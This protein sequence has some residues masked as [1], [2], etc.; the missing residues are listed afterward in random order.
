[1]ATNQSG[2]KVALSVLIGHRGCVGD[3]WQLM[4]S[5]ILEAEYDLRFFHFGDDVGFDL[6]HRDELLSLA[7]EQ[8][9]DLIMLYSYLGLP[10]ERNL[11]AS[12]KAQ[13][14]KPIIVSN[15]GALDPAEAHEAGVDVFLP[16][17]F[18][19]DDLR[20]ALAD[21]GVATHT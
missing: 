1:M 12:L 10:E 14:G 9:F 6:G 5:F 15:M 18:R 11:L 8:R 21:C 7:K 13:Y 3:A 16:M 4:L 17:S 19:V 20:K 2:G